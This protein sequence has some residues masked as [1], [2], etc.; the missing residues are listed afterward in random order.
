M[1]VFNIMSL[2]V[3]SMVYLFFTTLTHRITSM[4]VGEAIGENVQQELNNLKAN[5]EI[6]S[7]VLKQQSRYLVDKSIS[8]TLFGNPEGTVLVTVVTNPHCGPCAELHSRIEKLL[9]NRE[10]ICVQYIFTYFKY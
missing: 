5:G 4:I 1:L 10:R 6:Y 8:S 2:G 9:K 7:L 3:V